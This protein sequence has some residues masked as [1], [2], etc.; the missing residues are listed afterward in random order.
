MKK[1]LRTIILLASLALL[2]AAC[3]GEGEIVEVP[4][5]VIVPATPEAEVEDTGPQVEIPFLDAWA[6]SG[7]ADASAEAFKHW[8]EDD[9]AEVPTSCAKCHSETGYLDFLGLDGTEAGVV[10][11]AAPIGSVVSCVTCHNS[12]TIAMDSVVMP[13]GVEITGLGDESRCMQCH[14]GRSSS[15]TVTEAITAA[16]VEEDE[17]SEDLGFINIHYYAAAATK[18][19]TLTQGGYQYDGKSYDARFDHVEDYQTCIDCHNP[20]TLEIKINE[21]QACHTD[22]ADVEALKDVR[23]AGSLVDYDGDGDMSEGIF[24]EIQGLQELLYQAIQLYAA[25]VVGAPVVYDSHSY[26]YFFIDD[27]NGVVDEGEAIYPNKYASWTP[28]LLKAAYNYQVSLKD[29]GGFAHGGKYLIQLLFD[30]IEDLNQGIDISNASRIDHGHF[31]GSEEAFRHW[32]EDG[33][34]SSSCSRCHSAAGLPLYIA[35]GV[36][37]TQPIS[38]GLECATCHSS[39]EEFT[40]YEVGSVTFPSGAS[41]DSGDGRTNLCMSCHQ[42]RASTASVDDAVAGVGDDVVS[43]DLRF[44]NIHYFAA[45]ATRNGSDVQGI[46]QYEGKEYVGFFEHVASVQQCTDCHSAHQLEVQVAKCAD[47]HDG[48]VTKADLATIRESDT[49]DFDGDG[50]VE[51][52]LA[53]EV[54]GVHELLYAALLDYA[55]NTVG[56]PIIYDSHS[57]PYFFTDDGNGQVDPGEAIYPN[58]YASWTPTLLKAAYNYQYV[59]KDPGAFAHNARY[60]LQAMFD[61]IQD[62]GGSTA[63]LIR[64]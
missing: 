21:C 42:G 56:T 59:A 17:V 32:D 57:Y 36:T 16:G 11:N 7:H 14:Q 50:D 18:Y 31:A 39:L 22:A 58:R 38:N 61:S 29:P 26:P 62:L 6:S 40:L 19:G 44:I 48:V 41:V 4:V 63:G 46:Y 15:L 37:I 9:P 8:D 47:C 51:E 3:G 34:V 49:P 64:P 52:G 35:E 53:G 20:H 43:E 25:D 28:R 30:S 12:A 27:G 54:A 24:Y 60:V 45:G 2:I 5:T 13:S 23:M 10:D 33:E 55:A 1:S